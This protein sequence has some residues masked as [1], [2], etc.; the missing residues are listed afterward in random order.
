METVYD[1]KLDKLKVSRQQIRFER[2][3]LSWVL[4]LECATLFKAVQSG[5]H[6]CPNCGNRFSSETLFNRTKLA[7]DAVRFG[8]QYRMVYE[9]GL[10]EEGPRRH[11]SLLLLPEVVEWVVLAAISGIIGGA[12][13][14]LAKHAVAKLRMQIAA[15]P[16]LKDL[17]QAKVVLNEEEFRKL[18]V[19]V[20]DFLKGMENVPPEV[21]AAIINE[22]IMDRAVELMERRE[23]ASESRSPIEDAVEELNK[24]DL[25]DQADFEDMWKRM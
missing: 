9:E 6:E 20:A 19:Y 23:G 10:Q 12:S 15:E 1:E 11:H 2:S 17:E 3:N 4:C 14:D 16:E 7:S 25:L 24:E 8:Y 18:L 21:R 5:I 22:M 13:L